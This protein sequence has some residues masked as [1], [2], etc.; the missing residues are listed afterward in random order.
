MAH[1]KLYS[2]KSSYILFNRYPQ[3]VVLQIPYFLGISSEKKN[4]N[5][6]IETRKL[7]YKGAR[8]LSEGYSELS[9]TTKM[10]LFEVVFLQKWLADF[11]R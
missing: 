4:H 7:N 8:I 9:Q 11:S 10:V 1:A 6:S 2:D 3:N 5:L